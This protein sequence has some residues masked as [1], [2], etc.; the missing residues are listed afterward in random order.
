M[1]LGRTVISLSFLYC[2]LFCLLVQEPKGFIATSWLLSSGQR[3]RET[4]I[5]GARSPGE[6]E[7]EVV[8]GSGWGAAAEVRGWTSFQ[9]CFCAWSILLQGLQNNSFLGWTRRWVV[10]NSSAASAAASLSAEV[11]SL[12]TAWGLGHELTGEAAPT[13]QDK[14]WS[15]TGNPPDCWPWASLHSAISKPTARG[16]QKMT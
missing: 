8:E 11:Y 3:R 7:A 6:Q 13:A 14:P 2:V 15:H 9:D 5:L 10:L 16:S 1:P 4:S 12:A